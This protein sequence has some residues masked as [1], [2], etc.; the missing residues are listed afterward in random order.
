M[1]LNY[2]NYEQQYQLR[3]AAG[4]II[5]Q[6]TAIVG[7]PYLVEN[8]DT[9]AFAGGVAVIIDT[10]DA[11]VTLGRDQNAGTSDPDVVRL[12]GLNVA[13]A[14]SVGFLGVATG[15]AAA[16]KRGLVGGPGTITTVRTTS[17][18]IAI[19]D[20]ITGS[21]TAGLCAKLTPATTAGVR[22]GMCIK[23]NAQ[24]GSLGVYAAGVLVNPI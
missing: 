7:I 15:P 6:G 14:S 21:A 5:W 4:T 23:A 13:S 3:S 16:T 22:L 17:A 9:T 8:T 19:G 18:A 1:H 20:H 24:I 12:C 10:T 2:M 11:N